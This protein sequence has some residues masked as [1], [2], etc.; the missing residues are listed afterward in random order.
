MWAAIRWIALRL[1][2]LRWFFKLG[3]LGLL[4]PI[5]MLLKVIGLPLL[6]VLLIVGLPLLILLVLFGLPIFLVL[7]VAGLALGA[8]AFVLTIGVAAIKIGLFVVLPVWLVWM[9]ASK[10]F[11]WI[12]GRN[13]DDSGPPKSPKPAS[14]D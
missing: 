5:A 3:W 6:A 7:L 8:L 13:G 2:A 4:V 12:S 14:A 11:A 1:I 9:I 10:L